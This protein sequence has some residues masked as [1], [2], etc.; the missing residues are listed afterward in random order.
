VQIRA[1]MMILPGEQ[2]VIRRKAHA[3]IKKAFDENGI[4]FP[5]DRAGRGRSRSRLRRRRAARPGADPPGGG[6]IHTGTNADRGKVARGVAP[7]CGAFGL[8]AG[9][10]STTSWNPPYHDSCALLSCGRLSG[11][12]KIGPAIMKP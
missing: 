5:F 11:E 12:L 9:L 2:F 8:S 6:M 4:K 1:K 7:H 3:M 10:Y